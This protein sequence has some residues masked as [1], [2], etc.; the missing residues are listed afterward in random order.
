MVRTEISLFLKNVPGELGRLSALLA[1][2]GINIDALTI[3][4]ASSYVQNLFQARGKSL[5]RIASVASYNSMRKDSAK[6]ALI[7][8]LV[9][10]TDKTMDLLSKNDYIFD[11]TPVITLELQNSPG[12]LAAIANKFGEKGI[13]INYVYGSVSSPEE[14]CLFVFCPEDI[15]L[16]AKIFKKSYNRFAILYNSRLKRH[17]K[18]GNSYTIKLWATLILQYVIGDNDPL[19]LRSS[20]VNRKN[21]RISVETFNR[22]ILNKSVSTVHL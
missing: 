3:Q 21:S 19:Y 10:Q 6:F 12:S 15:E 16:A 13:N 1:N 20:L 2:E 5:K 11:I 4:D 7:R 9:D 14:K 22:I 8:L 18:K 17:L